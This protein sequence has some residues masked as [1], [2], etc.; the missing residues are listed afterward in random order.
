MSKADKHVLRRD[1]ESG[2]P[3][4]IIVNQIKK[5]CHHHIQEQTGNGDIVDLK[6]HPTQ[7]FMDRLNEAVIELLEESIGKAHGDN[8]MEL[9]AEDVPSSNNP[10]KRR[11]SDTP[12]L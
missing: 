4:F 12:S 3:I 8:R 9:I 10:T 7:K 6:I 5:F 11:R 1:G 2:L